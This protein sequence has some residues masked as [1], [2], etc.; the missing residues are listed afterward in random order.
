M[1]RLN[2][3]EDII[4]QLVKEQK[5]QKFQVSGFYR[6]VVLDNNDPLKI[7][8][9]KIF[10]PIINK[11][12]ST[13]DSHK[14]ERV[15]PI[16]EY[17][18]TPN[19][20]PF[21]GMHN[22]GWFFVPEIG[23]VVV[24]GFFDGNPDRMFWMGCVSDPELHNPPAANIGSSKTQYPRNR[25][26][27]TPAGHQIEID[28]SELGERIEVS[29]ANGNV[30][31]IEDYR[32]NC[33]KVRAKGDI[34]LDAGG[35]IFLN[36]S[37]G[38]NI[39]ANLDVNIVSGNNVN[40]HAPNGVNLENN[41]A[42]QKDLVVQTGDV[43][44]VNGNVDVNGDV[45]ATGNMLATGQNS[46]HHQ[47]VVI[48][49]AI[50]RDP[51]GSEIVDRRIIRANHVHTYMNKHIVPNHTHDHSNGDGFNQGANVGATDSKQHDNV[52]LAVNN[53]YGNDEFVCTRRVSERDTHEQ[54]VIVETKADSKTGN[55]AMH[56][57]YNHGKTGAVKRWPSAEDI[58]VQ[59]HQQSVKEST[60]PSML[61]AKDRNKDV[62]LEQV[63]RDYYESMVK[64]G[65]M[66]NSQ[67]HDSGFATL[68][69][70]H[71][72]RGIAI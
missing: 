47:H 9:M 66:D 1:P 35:S 46:N 54:E 36:A 52:Q 49:E 53:D 44:L 30:I 12:L 15:R 71:S 27:R 17:S 60:P 68:Q 20:T 70:S 10:V 61:D 39:N 38:V 14:D 67:L 26:L 48:A 8:R 34:F 32:D 37:G 42:I 19:V 21:G 64:S 5:D 31:A 24:C 29:S 55:D 56:Q 28:D 72:V 18:W 57:D 43:T 40:I 13:N 41:V 51:N 16:E 3:N 7:G 11:K 59:G 69:H 4:E 6:G 2:Y 25:V 23:A 63:D 65:E 62:I 58:D 50:D 45:L 33:I 22:A